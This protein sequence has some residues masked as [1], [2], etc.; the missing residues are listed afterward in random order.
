M[1]PLDVALEMC[2]AGNQE[3]IA[4]AIRRKG[5]LSS[6]QILVA[7]REGDIASLHGVLDRGNLDNAYGRARQILLHQAAAGDQHDLVRLLI[8]K[9][10]KVNVKDALGQTPLDLATSNDM[11][12]LLRKHG[13][14]HG[15][16]LE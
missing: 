11:K 3:Q 13:G 12:S 2:S 5:G 4:A 9:G 7:A 1:T 15:A 14:K 8:E 6:G 16:E 10:A